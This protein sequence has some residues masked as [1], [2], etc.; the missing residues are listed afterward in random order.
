MTSHTVPSNPREA[1]SKSS[2]LVARK[3]TFTRARIDVLPSPNGAQRSYYWDEKVR[4][5]GVAV[6]PLGKK[7]F[8]L[9][10]KVLGRPERITI[11]PCIDLSID[12][13]RNRAE[14]MNAA[15]AQ[16]KNPADAKR[17]VRDEMTL[18]ELFQAYLERHAK[19]HKRTWT[20]DEG[21]FNL[22]FAAWKFRKIS[23]INRLDVVTLHAR[24]GRTRGPYA[25]NRAVELLG[26]MFNRAREWGWEGENPASGIKA[27]REHKR[28]R[29]M[30]GAEL[31]AFFKSLA[32][33]PNETMRDF[34]LVALLTGARR[35][36]VQAMRW[37][38]INWDSDSWAIPDEK[39]KSG[40]GMNIALSLAVVRILE[41]RQANAKSEWVFPGCGKTGHVTEVKSAW[42]RIITRAKLADL[43]VHDLRRTLGS[44][45]AAQG[46]SLQ[47][48][49]KSLG[50]SSLEATKIYARLNLDPVRA[51]VTQAGDAMLLAGGIAGLLEGGQ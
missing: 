2:K 50:H 25:A 36:N 41:K 5:L 47:I 45:Q 30:D 49:G 9:Y 40:E 15:I 11:G 27:F 38:E 6:S 18:A 26:T 44:W 12:Q 23:S 43:R 32:A 42:K 10:R 1:G 39:S 3:F 20:D 13:A 4:G 22:H 29:F 16:G 17:A 31:Q 34:F 21:M 48:I 33:E 19:L 24:I 37:A 7:T 46:T 28:A 8:I 35:S 14:E 51:A